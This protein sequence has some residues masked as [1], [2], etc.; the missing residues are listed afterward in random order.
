MITNLNL[1]PLYYELFYS[2]KAAAAATVMWKKENK[3]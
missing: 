3:H 1:T 2:Y